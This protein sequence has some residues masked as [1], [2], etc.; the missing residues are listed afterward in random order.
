M[1]RGG[2]Q[3]RDAH[4]GGHLVPDAELHDVAGDEVPRGQRGDPAAVAKD[5]GVVGLDL[6]QRVQR[7]LR[8]GLL[9]HPDGCVHDEDEEDDERLDEGGERRGGAGGGEREEEGDG[10]GREQD[11]HQRVLELVQQQPQQRRARVLGQLVRPVDA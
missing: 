11:A 6:P 3:P 1:E 2:E 9:P 4:V 5:R 10:S 8:V 7:P